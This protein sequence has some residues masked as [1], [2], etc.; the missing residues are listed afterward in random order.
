MQPISL[1]DLTILQVS[2]DPS[3]GEELKTGT[4][5]WLNLQS[6][7]DRWHAME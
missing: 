1:M 3:L 7:W 4:E 2:T 5:F 6:H